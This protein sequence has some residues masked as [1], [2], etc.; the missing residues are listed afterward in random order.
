M[1]N[2]ER[3]TNQ[4]QRG[5]ITML[6]VNPAIDPPSRSVAG[7]VSC[8]CWL[9]LWIGIPAAAEEE[10]W[11]DFPEANLEQRLTEISDGEL[12]FLAEAPVEPAHHHENRISILPASL[13]SGWVVMEQCHRNLDQVS[14]LE[15]VYHP[16]RIRDI[17]ILT[18]HN[19]DQSRVLGPRVELRG[20]QANATL[21]LSAQSRALHQLSPG[22]YQLRNGPYMRRFLDGYYPLHLS[23]EIDYPPHLLS[24]QSAR[25]QTK[26]AP[27]YHLEPGRIRWE[28]WFRGRLNTVFTFSSSRQ[29]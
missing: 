23:I 26:D 24:L 4:R 11:P 29:P 9:L 14:L 3:R 16:E 20:V 25:P 5:L 8:F 18:S 10:P 17:R 28:A 12:V 7:A 6:H 22:R 13:D 2:T 27:A 19:I 21:C 1:I 15:I